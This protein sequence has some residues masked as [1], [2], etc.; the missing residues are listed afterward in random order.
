MQAGRF[1]AGNR[2]AIVTNAGG[3]A[4]LATDACESN[5]LEITDFAPS[6]REKLLAHAPPEASVVNPV[7]LIASADAE[8]FDH[9]L[10]AVLA[11]RRVDMVMA[12]FV[13][14]VMIDTEAVAKVFVRHAARS[15]KPV[16][17]CMLG[18]S[19]GERAVEVLRAAG[20][21]NYR[22]PEEAVQALAGLWQLQQLRTRP[23]DPI[24]RFRCR[25]KVAR[26]AVEQALAEGRETL[27]GVE[28]ETVMNAYGIP[29]VPSRIVTSREQAQRV[30]P[31]LGWPLVA[32][33]VA[34]DVVHKSDL[35]G[36]VLGIQ[37]EADLL[38]AY[39]KL[40]ERFLPGHPEMHVMLQAMRGE[41]V[42]LFFGAATDP[43]FGRMIAFGIGGIHVEVF[44]DV[45]FRLHPLRR[46]H[47]EE[48]VDGIR[49]KALL[50]GVRG[51]PPVDR[52]E[53]IEVLLR[54]SQML[55]DLPEIAE[56][57]LNPFLAGWRGKGSCV[58]DMRV[59]LERVEV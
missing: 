24:V 22:F 35:G 2:V 39:D 14:P 17:A 56:L 50:E 59:R 30:A 13:S 26:A 40:E 4:I 21:P 15:R 18:K 25:P 12:I 27:K 49:A 31:G 57:D 1:P 11:D 47:A 58:L 10:R 23:Q 9:A 55:T 8:R 16:V 42:E 28:L 6:T 33:V 52:E 46:S 19:Q 32:K 43:Q 51:K 36:V 7:D 3:P 29:V 37:N 5:G 41:G 54:L 48:M 44:K 38:A 20:V 34:R 45:V 53:L